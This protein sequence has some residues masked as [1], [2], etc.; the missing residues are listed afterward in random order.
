[1]EDFSTPTV[2]GE[3]PQINKY[4]SS[5]NHPHAWVAIPRKEGTPEALK[6]PDFDALRGRADFQK[7]VAEVKAKVE[8]K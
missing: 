1:M 7:L 3:G 6:D 5:E 4:P 8:K 2:H